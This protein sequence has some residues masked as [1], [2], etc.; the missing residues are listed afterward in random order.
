MPYQ[1][2]R[3]EGGKDVVHLWPHR[4]LTQRG[5]VTFIATTAALIAMPLL[6]VLGTPVLWGLLPFLVLT[7]A[8]LWL[9]LRKNGRDRD[10]LEV[11]ELGE[12]EITLRHRAAR[13]AEAKTWQA[14]PYWVRVT[15]HGQAGPV[16]H[17]LT[18]EGGP[19]SVEIGAFL[20]PEERLALKAELELRLSAR[21]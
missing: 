20:T 3:P 12:A 8:L 9:A 10:I 5:F 2:L 13:G 21:R 15:D 4:S 7:I 19:R 14:N 1:W 18:L 16:P 6:A 11:L 17:Y